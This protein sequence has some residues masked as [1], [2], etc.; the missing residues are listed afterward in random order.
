M[1]HVTESLL[2]GNTAVTL[3]GHTWAMKPLRALS[4]GLSELGRIAL[5]GLLVTAVALQAKAS[6][7]TEGA[8]FLDIPVGAGPASLGSAYTAL[9][10]DA[11]APTWN[12]GGLG[13][14]D[15]IGFAAQHLSYLESIH[16]EYLSGVLPLPQSRDSSNHRSL[17]FSAQYLASGDIAGTDEN[18]NSIGDFSSNY[19]AYNLS[20]GQT[21]NE[22]LAF[23]VTGKW[24]HENLAGFAASAWGAEKAKKMDFTKEDAA[25]DLL[26]N[27][28]IWRS[29]HGPN[30]AMP[31]P[32]RAAFVFTKAGKDDDD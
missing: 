5:A 32:R 17:G 20:Y 22:K 2:A 28:M 3:V 10:K 29:V 12:P 21:V 9:A 24:I 31:A 7:G 6:S 25:D 16:Y 23:G 27:E 4:A 8:S 15:G 1:S 13:F 14:V 18:G 19:G 11:Y 26:L 30:S